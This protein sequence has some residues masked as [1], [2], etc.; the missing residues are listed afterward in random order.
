MSPTRYNVHMPLSA[1]AIVFVE[2][3]TKDSEEKMVI[4]PL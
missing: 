2:V 4:N 3:L 1:A